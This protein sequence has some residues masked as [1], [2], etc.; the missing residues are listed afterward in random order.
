MKA[1]PSTHCVSGKQAN[2]LG[3]SPANSFKHT[4]SFPAQQANGHCEKS[5]MRKKLVKDKLKPSLYAND[6]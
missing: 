2:A 4:A 6:V 3:K 5:F 1:P